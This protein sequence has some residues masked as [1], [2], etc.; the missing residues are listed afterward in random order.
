MYGCNI[1]TVQIICRCFVQL[2][3]V[4]KSDICTFFPL[5][6]HLNVN[7]LSICSFLWNKLVKWVL[8]ILAW[9]ICSWIDSSY[10]LVWFSYSSLSKVG[11]QSNNVEITNQVEFHSSAIFKYATLLPSHRSVTCNFSCCASKTH[12]FT[13]S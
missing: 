1:H 7:H 12:S 4:F 10:D 6:L 9:K 8:S 11:V 5:V 13:V 2:W 3:C